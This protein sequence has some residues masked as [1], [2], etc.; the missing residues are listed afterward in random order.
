M[1]RSVTA[2]LLLGYVLLVPFCFFGGAFSGNVASMNMIGNPAHQMTDCSIPLGGCAQSTGSGA[3]DS[4]AHHVG[5]YNSITQTPLAVLSTMMTIM[6]VFLL[7]AVAP[8]SYYNWLN[9]FSSQS[10]LRPLARR[11]NE[12]RSNT[13]QSILIWL[14]LFETSPNFA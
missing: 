11:T 7:L 9:I 2:S 1:K 13:P 8:S 4:V 10:S 14:S 6:A 12:P 3:V 5:M